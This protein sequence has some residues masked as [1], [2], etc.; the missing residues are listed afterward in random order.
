MRNEKQYRN[1]INHNTDYRITTTEFI[2]WLNEHEKEKQLFFRSL[3]QIETT[4]DVFFVAV[5]FSIP[6][7]MVKWFLTT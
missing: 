6:V 7:I 3:K 1:E 5:D 2:L 4:E